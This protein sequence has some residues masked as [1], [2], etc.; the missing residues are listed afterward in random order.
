M[1]TCQ[2][3]IYSSSIKVEHNDSMTRNVQLTGKRSYTITLPKKWI[4]EHKIQ[5]KQP[6]LVK[7][8]SDGSLLIKTISPEPE[9][10][11]SSII[12]ISQD[13]TP[14]RLYQDLKS[15]YI[16][17]NC[18]I[19]VVS[20]GRFTQQAKNAIMNFV[21]DFHGLKITDQTLNS[22]FIEEIE[23]FTT[24]KISW[25]FENILYCT[26]ELLLNSMDKEVM[27][28]TVGFKK[29]ETIIHSINK[30]FLQILHASNLSHKLSS[31]ASNSRADLIQYSYISMNLD[32]LGR[33]IGNFMKNIKHLDSL[34]EIDLIF[35]KCVPIIS[36]IYQ[37]IQEIIQSFKEGKIMCE[38]ESFGNKISLTKLIDDIFMDQRLSMEATRIIMRIIDNLNQFINIVEFIHLFIH[39]L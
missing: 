35:K 5:K 16:E 39:T 1:Q 26:A 25:L 13:A 14:I 3:G 18:R 9:S 11:N 32:K 34:M 7:S 20:G 8:Q 4:E 23:N 36:V 27:C 10:I 12:N 24:H 22:V 30:N 33:I 6:L 28:N 37:T 17:G 2:K 19:V 38:M 15:A 21:N 31:M 29:S